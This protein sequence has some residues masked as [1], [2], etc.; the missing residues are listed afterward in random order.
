MIARL[1]RLA[2]AGEM[3]VLEKL[4]ELHGRVSHRR[5]MSLALARGIISFSFDDFPASA[6]RR[7]G[8][9][10]DAHGVHATYYV[11]MG[12]EGRPWHVG[13]GFSR[14]DLAALVASG[15]ELG[16]HTFSHQPCWRLSEAQLIGDLDRN[17]RLCR[18]VLGERPLATFAYPFGLAS[19]SAKRIV[20][21]R[22]AAVRHIRKGMNVGTIDLAELRANEITAATPL[23]A[24]T[25]LIERCRDR[26]GWLLFFTHDISE[27]PSPW[28]CMPGV[29]AK[30]VE[31]AVASGC[32]VLP[33]GAAAAAMTGPAAT[34]VGRA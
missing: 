30:L 17:A 13:E 7:G 12:L 31:Q 21:A 4:H 14:D 3:K 33:V 23:T 8:A 29:F 34:G 19:A 32:A 24:L 15:H 10:L 25:R 16:C 11:S 9:V 2:D 6:W 22:F 5:T 28:G 18:L 27:T 20:A 1:S 26:K